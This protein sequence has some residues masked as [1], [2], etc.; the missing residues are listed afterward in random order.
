LKEEHKLREF[1]NRILR[2]IFEP[3]RSQGIG[4]DYI[5]RSLTLILLMWRIG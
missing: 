2:R 1:E 5:T 3:K 4:E